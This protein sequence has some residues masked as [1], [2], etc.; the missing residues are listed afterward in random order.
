MDRHQLVT[1]AVT[2]VISVIA[3]EVVVWVFSL[4]KVRSASNTT[5]E[6]VKKIFSK[7]NRAIIGDLFWLVLLFV[8]LIHVMRETT[9]LTRFDIMKIVLYMMGILFWTVALMWDLVSAKIR[10][11]RDR[12]DISPST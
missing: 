10:R 5:K 12:R 8:L 6:S 3:K 1:I 9:P 11:E 7:T 4:V 2:A